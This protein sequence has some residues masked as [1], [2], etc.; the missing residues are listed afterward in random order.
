[1][2]DSLS[3]KEASK[4]IRDISLRMVIISSLL[5]LI[6]KAQVEGLKW[7]NWKEEIMRVQISLFVKDSH[8]L[9]IQ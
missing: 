1:M 4:P 7:E 8:R 2:V 3:F 9:L 6:N 5:D